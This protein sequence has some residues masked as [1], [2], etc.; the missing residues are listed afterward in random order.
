MIEPQA[1]TE[2]GRE[3]R[4]LPLLRNILT[5]VDFVA[6]AQVRFLYVSN[7]LH[8]AE[9]LICSFSHAAFACRL[10]VFALCMIDIRD[11]IPGIDGKVSLK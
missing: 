5:H 3:A 10:H 7:S 6:Q 4:R 11:K 9:Q 2:S 1:Q 8:V